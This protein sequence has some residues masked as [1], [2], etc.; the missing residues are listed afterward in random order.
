MGFLTWGFG[1]WSSG[2]TNV[3]TPFNLTAPNQYIQWRYQF[4][5]DREVAEK[6]SR[7]VSKEEKE[8]M[9]VKIEVRPGEFRKVEAIVGRQKLAKSFQY[10]I[11]WLN[12]E[13]RD[14]AWVPR[15]RLI[16]R[17]FTKLVQAFDDREASREGLVYRTLN[18]SEIRTHF[19][20]LGL[21]G[22]IA[23][24]IKIGMLSGGQKVKVVIGAAMWQNPQVLIM[25]EPT[26]FLDREALGGLAA[27]VRDWNGAVLLISHN[28]E[29]VSALVTETWNV[30]AGILTQKGKRLAADDLFDDSASTGTGAAESGRDSPAPF[31]AALSGPEGADT[32]VIDDNLLAKVERI[33]AKRKKLTNAQRKEREV[34]RR[35]RHLEWLSSGKGLEDKPVDTDSD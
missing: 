31:G 12:M 28:E 15:E 9:D 17:G 20:D 14:N 25:D 3:S 26:N 16:D 4:G 10:E 18:P 24:H 8:Q 23:D 13:H 32:A 27:A 7:K 29:F 30:E 19:E 22:D 34:R 5:E 1:T 11:K 2:D 35:L 21:E 6:E 33:K